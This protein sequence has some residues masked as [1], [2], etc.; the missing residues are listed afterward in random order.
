M[1]HTW[2]VS[3]RPH[4]L[5]A[6]ILDSHPG[7]PPPSPGWLLITLQRPFNMSTNCPLSGKLAPCS[8]I[9]SMARLPLAQPQHTG[10]GL[11]CACAR[12]QHHDSEATTTIATGVR[13][14]P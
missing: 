10:V 14:V 9:F 7:V 13:L 5:E 6:G 1:V 12:P 4:A 3:W 2:P 8:F 11:E